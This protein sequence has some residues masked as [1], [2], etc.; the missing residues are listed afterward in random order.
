M[1]VITV[2]RGTL[3]G[4]RQLAECICEKLGYRC[5]SREALV[6]AAQT[7][8]ISEG[9]LYKAITGVP[10]IMERFH[11]EKKRYLACLRASLIS[12]S[13]DSKI[14][15]QGHAGHF[16]LLGVPHTIKVRVIAN[17]EFRIQSLTGLQHLN[18][19]EAIK[20]IEKVDAERERWTRFLYHVDWRDPSLYDLVI[21]LDHITLTDACDILCHAANMEKFNPNP[22][23]QKLMDDLVLSSHL[24]AVIANAGKISGGEDIEIEANGGAITIKGTVGSLADVDRIEMIV[25][26][27]PGVKD[28]N[29]QMQVQLTG[30]PTAKIDEG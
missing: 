18:R 20:Y 12:L 24:E 26:T 3:S 27:T 29:S 5:V 11:S 14:V 8:G 9:K 2:S 13:R 1:A 30:I 10:G 21:N 16:L 6:E 23:S 15:Y 22:E 25:R 19:D 28:I 17:L 7:Y 4:G